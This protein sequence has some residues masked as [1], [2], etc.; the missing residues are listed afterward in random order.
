MNEIRQ[1]FSSMRNLSIGSDGLDVRVVQ[2]S[3]NSHPPSKLPQLIADGIFGQ[4]T[5]ARIKEFQR[6]KGLFADGVVGSQTLAALIGDEPGTKVHRCN[7]SNPENSS[8][9]QSR[10]FVDFF[11][12]QHINSG[13]QFGF[14]GGG[15]SG[16]SSAKGFG[17]LRTLQGIQITIAM[18]VYGYSLDF[19]TIYI[20]RNTGLGGRPFTIAF[21][22]GEKIFQI[23]NCG[24][25]SPDRKTLIHELAHV[26]QSQHHSDK[27]RYMV[28]AL[29]SQARA[30]AASTAAAITD[31]I[32]ALNK[33]FP[34][35][36]PFDAYAYS[37]GM[38][39]ASMAAE[40]MAQAVENG[41]GS[42]VSHVRSVTKN[43]VDS[44][45]VTALSRPGFADRRLTGV[46]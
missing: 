16:S 37:S 41:E 15:S 36:Y 2:L 22:D 43:M 9:G 30:V 18:T 28:N 8:M 4:N 13:N 45:C 19:S 11:R 10:D 21:R 17:T 42:I 29:D 25:Y 24:T 3:L 32:V 6:N 44:A 46:K 38:P 39:F 14:A 26:W 34:T 5:E 27:F 12:D 40:Q 7:C 23:M 31:P 33:D 20:S 1:I 35:F